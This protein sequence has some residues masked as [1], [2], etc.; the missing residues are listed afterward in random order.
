MTKELSPGKDLDQHALSM[1]SVSSCMREIFSPRPSNHI[2][3]CIK[4]KTQDIFLQR[5]A[6]QV[7]KRV[8]ML[9]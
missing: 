2:N 9:I 3:S 8:R 5:V 4:L 1:F 6:N 7:N